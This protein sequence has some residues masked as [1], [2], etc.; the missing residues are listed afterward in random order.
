MFAV[1]GGEA[2]EDG[3]FVD[4]RV[5]VVKLLLENGADINHCHPINTG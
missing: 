3:R 1:F 2:W 4:E 5:G